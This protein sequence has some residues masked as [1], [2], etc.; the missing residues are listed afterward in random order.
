MKTH[1]TH[2]F[3]GLA[4]CLAAS[5]AANATAA[6]TLAPTSLIPLHLTP[7]VEAPRA[8]TRATSAQDSPRDLLERAH[9]A[10]D[11]EHDLAA[12]KAG[13]E[14]ALAAARA[15]KDAPLAAEAEAALRA[16]RVRLG[17]IE[18]EA[19]APSE[20]TLDRIAD[21]LVQVHN[22][23]TPWEKLGEDLAL[24]GD[25]AV[26]VL[27]RL[28]AAPEGTMVAITPDFS[29]V[30]PSRFAASALGTID[31]PAARA[32]TL[33]AFR[34]ETDPVLRRTLAQ[35]SG[36]DHLELHYASA[37]DPVE[38]IRD[39]G[40]SRLFQLVQRERNTFMSDP[41]LG[42]D[43]RLVE[44][45]V[46]R[47]RAGRGEWAQILADLAPF[48]ALRELGE[49]LPGSIGQA[50]AGRVGYAGSTSVARLD[51]TELRRYLEI[52]S[53]PANDA[54]KSAALNAFTRQFSYF[55]L[56]DL[57]A[58]NPTS[59]TRDAMS[60][61]AAEYPLSATAPVLP[62]VGFERTVDVLSKLEARGH[63]LDE[64]ES[65]ALR[66]ELDT[67]TSPDPGGQVP[68]IEDLG[69]LFD[70]ISAVTNWS[71]SEQAT[72]AAVYC[73]TGFAQFSASESSFVP[74]TVRIQGF[75]AVQLDRNATQIGRFADRLA[76]AVTQSQFRLET[77]PPSLA[78][79]GNWMLES[80]GGRQIEAAAQILERSAAVGGL[81]VVS[82][83]LIPRWESGEISRDDFSDALQRLTSLSERSDRD[84]TVAF[85]LERA[86]PLLQEDPIGTM[87]EEFVAAAIRLSTETRHAFLDGIEPLLQTPAVA[88]LV[89]SR[90][91]YYLA[92]ARDLQRLLEAVQAAPEENSS[93]RADAIWR[94]GNALYEPA[95]DL[96]GEALR[97]SE[98][99]VREAARNT[100]E[101]FRQQR[102][103]L[104][105]FARWKRAKDEA[106]ETTDAL[107]ALLASTDRDVVLGA[108]EALGAVRAKTA[109][110][111]LVALLA[112]DDDELK[113]AV[114]TAIARIGGE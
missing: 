51:P 99:A 71:G 47:A 9:Y 82:R 25:T 20:E 15:A 2:R 83:I 41:R 110:P 5:P 72:S 55:Q 29:I 32:A 37:Q 95:I 92:G 6:Q 35:S 40:G 26:Q 27:A 69:R 23:V 28:L 102:E 11:H 13:F 74:V 44:I 36:A 30:A 8:A 68:S 81:D 77:V 89:A 90:L 106:K 38:A 97:S 100:L 105:E 1:T 14:A 108:V 54:Q 73:F 98:P 10:E 76:G 34:S 93:L 58:A 61:L 67:L 52:W 21:I 22:G 53:A 88:E 46:E 109:L 4:L 65:V 91:R 18:D 43:P 56:K 50:I 48:V 63:V 113:T 19:P 60:A 31:S 103:A 24:Y 96:I 114:R 78:W 86:R 59:A 107:V 57:W 79:F 101:Q 42:G 84:G 49:P 33:E 62:F 64:R 7:R 12:A 16:V 3:L 80:G 111:K 45:A 87:A 75:D 85:L 70:A 39:V 112:R 104:E 94:L 17:E 66:A